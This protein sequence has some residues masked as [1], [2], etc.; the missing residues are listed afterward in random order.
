MNPYLLTVLA[1]IIGLTMVAGTTLIAFIAN[2]RFWK[3]YPVHTQQALGIAA[4]TKKFSVVV[5][6][7]MLLLIV[8]GVILM[9]QT[10][11]A[12]AE[13]LWF[14]IKMVLVL[15]VIINSIIGRQLEK[16]VNVAMAETQAGVISARI[17]TL[18]GRVQLFFVVQLV[19]FFFIFAMGVLKIN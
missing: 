4:L 8:S 13:Q 1:H 6:I 14:R 11:G 2:R 19:I 16:R 12:Y 17:I 18:R 3:L 5:G 10:H 15:L 7:G 9:A